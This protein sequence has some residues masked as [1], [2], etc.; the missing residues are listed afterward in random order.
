[1]KGIINEILYTYSDIIGTFIIF[2]IIIMIY[3]IN[4]YIK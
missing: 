3:I 2:S 4:H 1:M